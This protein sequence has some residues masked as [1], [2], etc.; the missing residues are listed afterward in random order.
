MVHFP[1]LSKYLNCFRQMNE[2]LTIDITGTPSLDTSRG[3]DVL[4]NKGSCTGAKDNK[5]KCDTD[6]LFW[7]KIE[8]GENTVLK[9]ILKFLAYRLNSIS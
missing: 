5:S 3:S 6:Q 4:A 7:N 9:S 1:I 2:S 8:L